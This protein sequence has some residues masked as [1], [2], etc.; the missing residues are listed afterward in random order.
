[1]E[2]HIREQKLRI[3]IVLLIKI[4]S[5]WLVAQNIL[6]R[7]FR[8]VATHLLIIFASTLLSLVLY[9]SL[10]A[11]NRVKSYVFVLNLLLSFKL[12][13]L[14]L[15]CQNCR[16]DTFLHFL[17]NLVMIEA[18][19]VSLSGYVLVAGRLIAGHVNLSKV[20]LLALVPRFSLDELLGYVGPVTHPALHYSL[21]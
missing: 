16:I 17:V 4:T 19:V 7:G 11:H 6:A 21:H 14:S 20:E 5:F 9:I 12:F 10:R 2:L 15:K 18:T 3:H 8:G 1:M 13:G